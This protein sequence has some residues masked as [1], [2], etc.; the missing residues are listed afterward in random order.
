VKNVFWFSLAVVLVVWVALQEQRVAIE[1]MDGGHVWREAKWYEPA[2][3][4]QP[5]RPPGRILL[6]PMQI[7]P[8]TLDAPAPGG[9]VEL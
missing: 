4:C 2:G 3:T 1:C 6:P 9:G 5:A 8:P 7:N